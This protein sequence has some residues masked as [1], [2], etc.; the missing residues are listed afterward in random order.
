MKLSQV[1]IPA[2]ENENRGNGCLCKIRPT[3]RSRGDTIEQD[4][5]SIIRGEGDSVEMVS[6]FTG[7]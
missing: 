1:N 3:S 5:P 2:C 4:V 7:T 6:S